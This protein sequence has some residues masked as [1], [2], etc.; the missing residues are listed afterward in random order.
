[1]MIRVHHLEN[2]RSHRVLWLLE[3]LGRP[4]EIIH[5][6]RDPATLAAPAELKA[7]HPLGKSPVVEDEGI[8]P[9]AESGAILEYLLERYDAANVLAP[10][11]GTQERVLYLHWLHFAEG[12]AMPPLLVK[13]IVNRMDQA[14]PSV[15]DVLQQ[16]LTPLRTRVDG[17]I[18]EQLA[19]MEAALAATPHFA[20]SAFSAADIQMIFV[21]EAAAA[22]GGLGPSYPKLWDWLSRMRA[23]P[24]WQ[25]ALERGGPLRLGS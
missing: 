15:R 5:Y 14:P 18:A 11:R 3:E 24:G 20:G 21:A 2:S 23:R 1:M 10:L 4:Y 16:A 19:Y 12:S 17:Q 6:K 9:L 25:R 22:R 7:V 8:A 13:L